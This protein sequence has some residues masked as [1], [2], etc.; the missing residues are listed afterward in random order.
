VPW[1]FENSVEMR[2]I[3]EINDLEGRRGMVQAL[4]IIHALMEMVGKQVIKLYVPPD[5][6]SYARTRS[7][8]YKKKRK[9]WASNGGSNAGGKPKKKR[10]S[11]KSF[12]LRCGT[13]MMHWVDDRAVG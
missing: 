10:T 11:P 9:E 13:G 5:G 12:G 4:R 1:K 8:E 7:Q 3:A 6:R 2:Q